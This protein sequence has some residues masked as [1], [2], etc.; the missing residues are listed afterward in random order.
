MTSNQPPPLK[1]PNPAAKK[2]ARVLLM[3]VYRFMQ[4]TL[5]RS[6][7]ENGIELVPDYIPIPDELIDAMVEASEVSIR[8]L[9]RVLKLF[10]TNRPLEADELYRDW[11]KRERAVGMK[12]YRKRLAQFAAAQKTVQTHG[13]RQ[14]VLELAKQKITRRPG[15]SNRAIAFDLSRELGM[16]EETIRKY[17]PPRKPK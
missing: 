5:N 4:H 11:Y 7:F 13:R 1:P 16:P 14:K 15:R 3:S 10:S 6:R 2:N 9:G 12:E 8:D 17:L